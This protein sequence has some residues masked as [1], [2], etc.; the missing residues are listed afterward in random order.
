MTN[1]ISI[2]LATY[3]G[4]LVVFPGLSSLSAKVFSL[5]DPSTGAVNGLAYV[6]TRYS[7]DAFFDWMG[8]K[9]KNPLQTITQLA[10][11]H[12]LSSAASWAIS[13]ALG[14]P[15]TFKGSIT[16][17]AASIATAIGIVFAAIPVVLAATCVATAGAA[18]AVA[19]L[20]PLPSLFP[21]E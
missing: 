15:I 14:F 6:S 2:T 21:L 18:I 3:A 1:D 11:S 16:L 9:A 17:P 10:L 20:L 19:A 4:G 8:I 7:I 12:L 5:S 13:N